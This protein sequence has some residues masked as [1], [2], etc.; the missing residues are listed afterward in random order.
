MLRIGELNRIISI[1][2]NS[3]STFSAEGEPISSWTS[4][5]NNA[6][7]KFEPITGRE[8]FSMAQR[9]SENVVRFTIRYIPG[10]NFTPPMRV[11]FN[12]E[13]YDIKYMKDVSDEHTN[14]EILAEKIS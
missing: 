10:I 2:I 12:N 7:A 13:Y 14:L 9:Y 11:L 3:P 4:I 8:F 6:W 5:L 1:Q